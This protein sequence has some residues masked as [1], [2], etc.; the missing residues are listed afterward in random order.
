MRS[1]S[2]KEVE[3]IPDEEMV[4]DQEKMFDEDID[5]LELD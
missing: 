4:E 2:N 1:K 3:L 5:L